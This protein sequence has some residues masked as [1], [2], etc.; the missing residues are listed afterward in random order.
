MDLLKRLNCMSMRS[1]GLIQVFKFFVTTLVCW[2]IDFLDI[3]L[4]K[5]FH[6]KS[7]NFKHFERVWC[8]DETRF[9]PNIFSHKNAFRML[10]ELFKTA[11]E[12]KSVANK[13]STRAASLHNWWE[14][15][16][17]IQ[18]FSCTNYFISKGHWNISTIVGI[19]LMR[20][21]KISVEDSEFK[22]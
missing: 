20:E 13:P 9:K 4:S 7:P 10:Y 5:L 12:W 16:L 18:L 8:H 3:W 1:F 6:T 15:K 22:F 19:I 14:I 17:F 2:Q 11:S 21:N